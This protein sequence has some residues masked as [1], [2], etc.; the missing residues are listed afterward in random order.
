MRGVKV[1]WAALGLILGVLA[2]VPA[3]SEWDRRDAS[4]TTLATLPGLVD[5]SGN[6]LDPPVFGP[7]EGLTVGVDNNI[8]A[9]SNGTGP[10]ANLFVI[11]PN[12]NLL[13]AGMICAPPAV[14]CSV[15]IQGSSPNVLGIRFN[16]INQNVLW[17][18][19]PGNKTQ[20]PPNNTIAPQILLVTPSTGNSTRANITFQDNAVLNGITFDRAGNAYVSD[21]S[22]GRIYKITLPCDATAC[23]TRIWSDHPALKPHDPWSETN[24]LGMTPPF[25]ANGIE[26][27][28]PNCTPETPPCTLLVANTANRQI[29]ALT[30][31]NA[32]GNAHAPTVFVK[33]VNG[34]D[35]I[36]IDT[37]TDNIWVAANQ[38]DEIV[39]IQPAIPRVIAKLGDFNGIDVLDPAAGTGTVRE[40]L[41]PTS[42][43]FSNL[44]V[45]PGGQRM[46][47]VA[48][49]AF[50]SPSSIDEEWANLITQFTVAQIPVPAITNCPNPMCGL[51]RPP[52]P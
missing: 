50:M 46:L 52:P 25:G 17:V 5:A 28:P 27:Q 22:N 24:Q 1:A 26:F 32:M 42:L 38:S 49:S 41:F 37:A 11:D 19:D 4:V 44:P 40:L 21:S 34:P 3:S 33:G 45:P 15:R 36:A 30:C 12:G 47:Y 8:Y 9:A 18:L 23:P 31:C 13:N 43:A 14:Q 35:G 16:P 51:F 29:L 2:A 48:N 39:V 6:L 10:I 7:V 20:P